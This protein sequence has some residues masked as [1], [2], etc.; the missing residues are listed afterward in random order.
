MRFVDDALVKTRR[1]SRSATWD[2]RAQAQLA[3]H[4]TPKSRWIRKYR[5]RPERLAALQRSLV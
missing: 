5:S 1:K 2:A 4:K 3:N